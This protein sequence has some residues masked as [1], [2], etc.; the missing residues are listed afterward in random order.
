MPAGVNHH[1]DT[2]GHR[3]QSV[4]RTNWKGHLL[5]G[6]WEWKPTTVVSRHV[7]VQTCVRARGSERDPWNHFWV[8]QKFF[9]QISTDVVSYRQLISVVLKSLPNG[10]RANSF[11]GHLMNTN[12]MKYHPSLAWSSKM[13]MAKGHT[14]YCR[15]GGGSRNTNW[16]SVGWRPMFWRN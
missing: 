10:K 7:Q 3:R 15:P 16:R 1:T 9:M 13:Y 14:L 2:S 11:D 12:S 6:Q 5:Q 4:G 8:N